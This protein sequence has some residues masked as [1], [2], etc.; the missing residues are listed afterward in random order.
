[1]IVILLEAGITPRLALDLMICR[2]N[3]SSKLATRD[4]C[5]AGGE[6][7]PDRDPVLR[8]LAIIAFALASP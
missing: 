4:R 2:F 8:T 3:E 1:V 5:D 7:V 6:G